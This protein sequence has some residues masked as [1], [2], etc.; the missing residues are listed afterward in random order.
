MNVSALV[1]IRP[2]YCGLFQART[3]FYVH[4]P[5]QTQGEDLYLLSY[6]LSMDDSSQASRCR[7][8]VEFVY[9]PT[10]K[11]LVP[12]IPYSGPGKCRCWM[13]FHGVAWP[14]LEA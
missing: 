13:R 5:V 8:S 14:L 9:L 2:L 10:S 1:I 6:L 11:S 12:K 4:I 3:S 7:T